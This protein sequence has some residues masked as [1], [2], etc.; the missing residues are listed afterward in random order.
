MFAAGS[1][2]DWEVVH[3]VASDIF[4]DIEK[5]EGQA[6]GFDYDSL[7]YAV[8]VSTPSPRIEPP[9]TPSSLAGGIF[10]VPEPVDVLFLNP[11]S[12]DIHPAPANFLK[13]AN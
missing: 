11:P 2:G 13:M 3:K 6:E 5:I 8:T 12:L 10:P 7:L 4:F 1:R 9:T